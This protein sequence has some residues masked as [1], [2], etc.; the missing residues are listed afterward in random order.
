MVNQKAETIG[1]ERV[2]RWLYAKDTDKS[3]GCILCSSCFGNGPSNPFEDEPGS[4]TQCPSYQF[5]KFV[6]FT[7]RTRWLMAQR[8]YYGMEKITPELK[9]VAYTCTNCQT[10]EEICG[11]RD[12]GYGPWEINT[13]L[14]ETIAKEDGFMDQHLPLVESIIKFDNP[15]NLSKEKRGEWAQGLDLKDITKEKAETLYFVGCAPAYLPYAR[16]SAKAF[17]QI[18]KASGVDF[19]IL[20]DKEKCCGSPAWDIGARDELHRLME[21][22]VSMINDLGVKRVVTLCAHCNQVMK[23]AYPKDKMNFEVLHGTEYLS[24]L[25]KEGKITFSNNEKGKV[26]YHDPCSLGRGCRV[27]EAPRELINAIPGIEFVEMRRHGRWS[28]C[29]GAGGGV[30][31]SYPELANWSASERLQE[32]MTTGAET[33]LTACPHCFENFIKPNKNFSQLDVKDIF[34]FVLGAMEKSK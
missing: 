32:A 1:L 34:E 12:D 19:G 23:R 31:Y 21:D 7:A 6:R 4:N 9:E 2:K 8:V 28:W 17:A 15:Y 16:K 5:Y 13:A 20:G 10:C 29:C 30:K 14:K 11:I 27:F 26:T 25:L 3:S 33:M 18:M 22:N 24:F